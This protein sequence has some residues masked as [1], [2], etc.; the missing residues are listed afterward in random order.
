M[1]IGTQ[2]QNAQEHRGSCDKDHSISF[3]LSCNN[4]EI[5]ASMDETAD[6]SST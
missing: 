5:S 6:H 3:I 1:H 4:T 2:G